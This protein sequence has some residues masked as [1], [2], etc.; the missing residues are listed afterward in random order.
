MPIPDSSRTFLNTSGRCERYCLMSSANG[1]SPWNPNRA[2]ILMPISGCGF[3]G[4]NMW[5]LIEKRNL[6][7]GS[8]KT[9][10]AATTAPQVVNMNSRRF[11]IGILLR[12]FSVSS[13]RREVAEN[14][15]LKEKQN[16]APLRLCDKIA[17]LIRHLTLGERAAFICQRD[18]GAVS[19]H[20]SRLD[21]LL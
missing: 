6:S 1:S 19:H 4:V 2:A 3:M 8:A 16:S 14:F 5:L 20:H 7:P 21:Q 9:L 18:V 17:D 13:Q 11:N 10:V 12:K 15:F